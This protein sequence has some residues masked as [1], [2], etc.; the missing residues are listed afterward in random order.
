[1][2]SVVGVADWYRPM[3]QQLHH[4]GI[5]VQLPEQPLFQGIARNLLTEEHLEHQVLVKV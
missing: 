4:Q 5:F 1:M 2:R 3:V